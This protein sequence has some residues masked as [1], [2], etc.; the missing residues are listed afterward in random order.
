[1]LHCQVFFI[2]TLFDIFRIVNNNLPSEGHS[3]RK[4][5][6]TSFLFPKHKPGDKIRTVYE[7]N[8]KKSSSKGRAA[9]P[10]PCSPTR[11]NNPHPNK[12]T[13]IIILL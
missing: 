12:V 13:I 2:T 10:R 4:Q 7:I 5:H 6:N 9:T 1:M 11:R 8:F 3:D